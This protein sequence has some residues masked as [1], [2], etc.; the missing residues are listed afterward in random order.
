[1]DTTTE[2]HKVSARYLR[3][4]HDGREPPRIPLT[5]EN[6]KNVTQGAF[7]LLMKRIAEKK[8]DKLDMDFEK[9]RDA[10]LIKMR[11]EGE[12]KRKNIASRLPP[13]PTNKVTIKKTGGKRKHHTHRKSRKSNKRGGMD[14]EPVRKIAKVTPLASQYADVTPVDDQGKRL[15][16][17][18]DTSELHT[19]KPVFTPPS[20]PNR[21]NTSLG[22]PSPLHKKSSKIKLKS[23]DGLPRPWKGGVKTNSTTRRKKSTMEN[24]ANPDWSKGHLN[25]NFP[26]RGNKVQ[27]VDPWDKLF[28]EKDTEF[29]K[30]I[31]QKH[32]DDFLLE[33]MPSEP[34]IDPHRGY[35]ETTSYEINEMN[36]KK[37]GSKYTITRYTRKQA[38]KHGVKVKLST[39]PKKKIDVFKKGKKIASVGAT[40][41]G[42]FPTFQKTEGMK[43]AK[44]H[45]KNYKRRHEKDRHVKG[46]PG[47]YAD[48]LLW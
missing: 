40:G 31:E 16:I 17:P 3:Q 39:N 9:D 14:G 4:R 33:N 42:D 18:S 32:E 6:T 28:H 37:G 43:S 36:K 38:K 8:T 24:K 21:K 10:A 34:F 15:R 23:D 47:F 5:R 19:P 48:K 26:V 11:E 46:S 25:I 22:E 44:R 1:M 45:R 41:Y 13:P 12:R 2:L 35:N 29:I 30:K 27:A 7:M 20:S